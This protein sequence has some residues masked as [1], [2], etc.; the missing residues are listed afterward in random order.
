M[1]PGY[2]CYV[3][4][5]VQKEGKDVIIKNDEYDCELSA[6][7]E[8]SRVERHL[9]RKRIYF[10]N[11]IFYD[12]V[13]EDMKGILASLDTL[14]QTSKEQ[15]NVEKRQHKRSI[16]DIVIKMLV[17]IFSPVILIG[18][19]F[20]LVAADDDSDNFGRKVTIASGVIVLILI[21]AIILSI[22]YL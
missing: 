10:W 15:K 5:I 20:G 6:T 17:F 13:E 7:W 2:E 4:C 22:L 3:G 14:E 9:L 11:D 19:F 18:M 12:D 21:A 8:I 16:K 1:Q